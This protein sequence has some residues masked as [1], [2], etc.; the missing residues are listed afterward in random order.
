MCPRGTAKVTPDNAFKPSN[1]TLTSRATNS[2]PAD[3]I[4]TPSQP[5]TDG[6]IF[7]FHRGIVK[8]EISFADIGN[9]DVSNV[10]SGSA[11]HR[12]GRNGARFGGGGSPE[13]DAVGRYGL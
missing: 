12:H 1:W 4:P 11:F 7:P 5:R 2:K 6:L 9:F 13:R 3:I 10:P 8:F